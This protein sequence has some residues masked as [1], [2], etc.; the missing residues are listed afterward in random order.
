MMHTKENKCEKTLGYG[1]D[2]GWDSG[3]ARSTK[4]SRYFSHTTTI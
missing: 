4:L 2:T 3:L 1:V